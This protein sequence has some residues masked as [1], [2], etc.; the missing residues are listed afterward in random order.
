MPNNETNDDKNIKSNSMVFTTTQ[1]LLKSLN[2][3]QKVIKVSCSNSSS[4]EILLKYLI[5]IFIKCIESSK[6][7]NKIVSD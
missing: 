2:N 1:D 5:Y 3:S 7:G 4:K 6:N